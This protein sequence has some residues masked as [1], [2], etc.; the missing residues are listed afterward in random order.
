MYRKHFLS[1]N[2]V[3]TAE[4]EKYITKLNHLK[5][6]RRK[7]YHCKQFNLHRNNLKATCKL[8]GTLIKRKTKGQTSPSRIIMNNKTFNNKSDNA[9]QF[10][11][12]FIS[13]GPSLATTIDHHDDEPTK[14]IYLISHQSQVLSCPLSRQC[15]FVG[16][17]RL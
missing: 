3:K 4:Y 7:V 9:E 5:T 17:S 2:P 12:Y 1:N 8:I 11:Y 10:N 6:V 15:K 14:Y 16:F 13:V